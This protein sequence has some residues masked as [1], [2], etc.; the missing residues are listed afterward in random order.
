MPAAKSLQQG[1]LS[2]ARCLPQL[3]PPQ[4]LCGG[5]G[6]R[7]GLQAEACTQAQSLL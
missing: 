3:L 7:G 1:A 6:G 5:G 4:L 2:P